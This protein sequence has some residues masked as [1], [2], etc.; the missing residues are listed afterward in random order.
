MESTRP[1]R[2]RITDEALFAPLSLAAYATWALVM[3]DV[4]RIAAAADA[5][6][7]RYLGV[8]AGVVWLATYVV[9]EL[10]RRTRWPDAVVAASLAV[11]ALASLATVYYG[12][13]GVA[14]VLLVIFA[15]QL[16]ACAPLRIVVAVV[17]ACNVAFYAIQEAAGESRA[18]FATAL[19][20]GFQV[21]AIM[22]MR[23][24]LEAERA[25]DALA[26]ANAALVATRSLLDESAR[27]EE[28]LRMSRELHDVAGHGLTALKLNLE[29]AQRTVDPE[30][31]RRV[32]QAIEL[33]DGLLADL[34]GMVGQL[35]HHDGI[36]VAAALAALAERMPGLA[37]EVELDPA[38]RLAT[39]EQ[40]E[41][42]LRCVQEAL[43]NAARHAAARRVRVRVRREDDRVRVTIADDGRG[44]AAI[45]PGHGLAGMRERLA[46]LGGDVRFESVP[47]RG[48][49]VDAS[50]PAT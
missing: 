17:V 11:Q 34:R 33:A 45:V 23:L 43:T 28:R 46:A 37:V 2:A 40:G 31:G 20:T 10:S 41:A 27:A 14:A 38:L 36:D 29:L 12:R 39:V 5:R 4:W 44:S 49:V 1:E 30:R 19:Y 13:S 7:D 6:D 50:L 15:A 25:R 8:L 32:R 35:R 47:G 3:S 9:R 24:A 16:A 42:L 18:L 48:F 21:F 22:A 26:A